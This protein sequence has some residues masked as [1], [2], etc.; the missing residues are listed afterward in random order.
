[1]GR[2]DSHT[3]WPPGAGPPVPDPDE[4]ELVPDGDFLEAQAWE[5]GCLPSSS[6]RSQA[7]SLSAG[8]YQLVLDPEILSQAVCGCIF[9]F[10]QPRP[11]FRCAPTTICA[12]HRAE[13]GTLWGGPHFL[14]HEM[15]CICKGLSS[16]SSAFASP[17]GEAKNRPVCVVRLARV[18]A[19][20]PHSVPADAQRG[21]LLTHRACDFARRTPYTSAGVR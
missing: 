9:L 5:S 16:S 12:V 4:Y 3:R 20:V 19:L 14:Y 1:M 13:M 11:R 8:E 2:P 18:V 6:L 15:R 17:A 21:M 7:L 10:Q